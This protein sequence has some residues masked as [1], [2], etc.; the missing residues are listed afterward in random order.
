MENLFDL[1]DEIVVLT[2]GTGTIGKAFSAALLNAG[3]RVVLWSRGRTVPIEDSVREVSEKCGARGRVFG[4]KVDVSDKN[5]VVAGL[6][7]VVEDIGKPSVL[8]NWSRW[9]PGEVPVH[10]G[11]SG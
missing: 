3:A 2:G 10:R 11:R 1:K 9:E 5:S 4:Y 8:I 7:R 6:E